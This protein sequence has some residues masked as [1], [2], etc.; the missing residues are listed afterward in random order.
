MGERQEPP[1]SGARTRT[2]IESEREPYSSAVSSPPGAEQ[3]TTA[4]VVMAPAEHAAA[5]MA[6]EGSRALRKA[7]ALAPRATGASAAGALAV[8]A[9]A[10][11]AVA[12]GAL[13]IGRLAVGALSMGRGHVRYL[14]I[15]DLDV[16]RLRVG[17]LV[18][19]ADLFGRADR[20]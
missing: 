15:D 16:G 11:G 19:D 18:A 5:P 8:G 2:R 13:A 17:E 9:L 4:S 10:V 1:E 6:G 14:A 3:P 7:R 12:V 20:G